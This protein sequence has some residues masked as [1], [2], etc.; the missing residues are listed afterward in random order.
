MRGIDISN[1]NP[2]YDAQQIKNDGIEFV[3]LKATEGLTFTDPT[4]ASRYAQ[5]KQAGLLA[6]AYCFARPATSTPQQEVAHFVDVVNQAGG[7]ESWTEFPHAY[8][9]ALDLE[10]NG[11]MDAEELQGY[12]ITW[13]NDFEVLTGRKG[14]LYTNENFFN[15]Y[16]LHNV[17]DKTGAELW[18]AAWGANEPNLKEIMWQNSD[19]GNLQGVNGHVDTDEIPSSPSPIPVQPVYHS[20][21]G[22]D[23]MYWIAKNNHLTLEELCKLNP[24][25][26]DPNKIFVG[27]Q[28]RIR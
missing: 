7:F 8:V 18:I 1:N 5:T 17:I 2:S 4:F 20:V 23:T 15:Q 19:A 28:V 6:G 25:I 27:E 16:Q 3:I 21:V 26:P 13:L 12:A 11:N 14:F 22:G 9:G 24:Q 10:D